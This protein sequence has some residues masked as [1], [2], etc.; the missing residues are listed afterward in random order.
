[1]LIAAGLAEPLSDWWEEAL[2]EAEAANRP[3]FPQL[4]ADE[5][6]LDRL[7]E[8]RRA[9]RLVRG[10]EAIEESLAAAQ[11]GLRRAPATQVQG[12][13]RISRLLVLTTDAAPRL[14]RNAVTLRRRFE[15]RLE[16]LVLDCDEFALGAAVFGRGQR[17][18]AVLLNHKEA[19]VD[20]LATI[21]VDLA[22]AELNESLTEEAAA[23]SAAETDEP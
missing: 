16:I 11:K 1:M 3:L 12:A 2:E 8:A 23:G 5:V 17:V 22:G 20:F 9:R 7:F 18:R 6:F 19:V 15:D 21:A 10:F 14:Y 13:R 4:P